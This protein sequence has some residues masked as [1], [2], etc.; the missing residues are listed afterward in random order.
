MKT[1]KLRISKFAPILD[2]MRVFSSMVRIA[3]NRF[4]EG[5][6]EKEIRSYLHSRFSVNSWLMQSAV[7]F[8]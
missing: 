3:F 5:F 6:S 1:I 8:A 4:Q 7:N 2:D